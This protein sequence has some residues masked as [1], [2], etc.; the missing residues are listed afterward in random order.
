MFTLND[1]QRARLA[2][3]RASLDE[4]ERRF[5]FWSRREAQAAAAQAFGETLAE[6][7]LRAG[8]ALTEEARARLL[9]AAAELAPNGNLSRRLYARDPK[10]FDARLRRL[11]FGD[12]PLHD[13][14]RAFL[15]CAGQGYRRL[16]GC[17]ARSPRIPIPWSRAR[18]CGGW[19]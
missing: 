12:E 17:S 16:P 9:R 19:A 3:I 14:L 4:G 2:A 8:R 13:R 10:G 6:S 1:S 7:G 5:D 18:P 11:L 15:R